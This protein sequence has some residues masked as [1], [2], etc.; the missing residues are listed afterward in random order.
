MR[1]FT[2]F[3]GP[4]HRCAASSRTHAPRDKETKLARHGQSEVEAVDVERELR[5]AARE[6]VRPA[7]EA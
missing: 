7:S 6:P 1:M 2:A 4:P 3:G 5:V